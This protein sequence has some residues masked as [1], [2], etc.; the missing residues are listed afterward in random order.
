M[1]TK[2]V[3]AVH[4]LDLSAPDQ[5]LALESH[6]G[7]VGWVSAGGVTQGVIFT[8]SAYPVGVAVAAAQRIL[9][10]VPGAAV[11]RVDEELVTVGDIADRL[12]VS[13]ES[14]RLW[15]VGKRR[16]AGRRFPVPRATLGADRTAMN[17]WAW[18]DVVDWLRACYFDPEPG[19]LYLSDRETA[20]L[21]LLLANRAR[22]G[23]AWLPIGT[24]TAVVLGEV[25]EAIARE[26]EAYARRRFTATA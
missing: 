6:V 22:S 14:V 24:T 19:V 17:A 18:G 12:S 16:A 25:E 13:H 4:G 2:I 5:M 9:A 3:L 7:N 20:E 11:P 21:N 10:L 8:D 1:T 26:D 23:W 15:T